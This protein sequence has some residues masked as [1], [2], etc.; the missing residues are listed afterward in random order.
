MFLKPNDGL[1]FWSNRKRLLM[2]FCRFL[3]IFLQI[4]RIFYGKSRKCN[5][6]TRSGSH[7]IDPKMS[8]VPLFPAKSKVT[9]SLNFDFLD[10]WGV[11]YYCFSYNAFVRKMSETPATI[12]D[13]IIIFVSRWTSISNRRSFNALYDLNEL[14]TLWLVIFRDTSFLSKTFYSN[15]GYNRIYYSYNLGLRNF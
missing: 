9:Y 7:R 8:D 15:L 14:L 2:A 12:N 4:S 10:F 6:K 3:Q 13:K 5:R 11:I 1:K